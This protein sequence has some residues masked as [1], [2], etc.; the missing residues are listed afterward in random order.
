MRIFLF[1]NLNKKDDLTANIVSLA[2]VYQI[3]VFM[4]A[5][6]VIPIHKILGALNIDSVS[7]YYYV[8][9]NCEKIIIFTKFSDEFIAPV[10]ESDRLTIQHLQLPGSLSILLAVTHLVDKQ[11]W[12]EDSQNAECTVLADSI[13]EAENTV[14]HDRTILVGDLNMNP[15]QAGVVNARGL[16]AVMTRKIALERSRIVQE[17]SYKFFYNPMWSLFGD[18]TEGPPGTYY[19][20]KSIHKVYFWNMLDQVLIRPELLPVFNNE[21]L[22]ILDNDGVTSLATE[23]GYPNKNNYSDHF[24][25]KFQL[26]I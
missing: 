21:D 26:N 4:F 3:D 2:N 19:L 6:C 10:V 22:S 11:N 17:K 12:D 13:E 25:I 16:H 14:E 7:E 15:F 8:P 24:P 1:W 9:T 5:E 23:E 20:R 18:G